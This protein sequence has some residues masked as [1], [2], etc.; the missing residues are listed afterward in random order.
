M[1]NE[2]GIAMKRITVQRQSATVF[3]T[4][5]LHA[6]CAV[7]MRSSGWHRLHNGIEDLHGIHVLSLRH[8]KLLRQ[9]ATDVLLGLIGHFNL[10]LFHSSRDADVV[11]PCSH[12]KIAIFK[13]SY[14]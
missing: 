1:K 12:T 3:L 6:K 7:W 14:L 5:L 4:N 13:K 8:F 11:S 9:F 10:R 2:I